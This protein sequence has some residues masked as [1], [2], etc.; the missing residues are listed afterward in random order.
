MYVKVIYFFIPC[1]TFV[2]ADG[3]ELMVIIVATFAQALSGQAAAVKIIGVLVV[4]RFIVSRQFSFPFPSCFNL[5][6]LVR[7]VSVLEEIIL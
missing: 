4:W 1:L 6:L 3:I 2:L 7:W 5:L